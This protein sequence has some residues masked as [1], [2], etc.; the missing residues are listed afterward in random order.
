MRHPIMWH[1]SHELLPG[2]KCGGMH[3]TLKDNGGPKYIDTCFAIWL[4]V[5]HNTLSG[6]VEGRDGAGGGGGGGDGDG[7][8]WAVVRFEDLLSYFPETLTQAM[9]ALGLNATTYPFDAVSHRRLAHGGRGALDHWVSEDGGPVIRRG[10]G[11]NETAGTTTS[12]TP[13]VGV[14][15]RRLEY[16]K[17][18]DT[19]K[20]AVSADYLWKDARKMTSYSDSAPCRASTR[21]MES[22]VQEAFGYA[23]PPPESVVAPGLFCSSQRPG[24]CVAGLAALRRE[25]GWESACGV[26]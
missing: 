1:Y 2:L 9:T 22:A 8:W 11:N 10:Q 15:G 19:S 13:I 4:E 21:S 6:L 12:S 26:G 25:R 20:L 5:W 14:D 7:A 3:P 18:K 17:S 16:H 24:K 23:F